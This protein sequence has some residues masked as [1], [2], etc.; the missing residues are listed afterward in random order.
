M[1]KEIEFS[2]DQ[3]GFGLVITNVTTGIRALVGIFDTYEEAYK[4]GMDQGKQ[5][6]GFRPE[7]IPWN[8]ENYDKYIWVIHKMSL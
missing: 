3:K 7:V 4:I 5:Q 6:K 2:E 8:K 1:F